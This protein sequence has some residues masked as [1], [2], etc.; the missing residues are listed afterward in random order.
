MQAVGHVIG[1]IAE[2]HSAGFAHRK[3]KPEH[4]CCDP[5]LTCFWRATNF[6]DAALVGELA[7][8]IRPSYYGP[9]ERVIAFENGNVLESVDRTADV[10]AMGVIAFE[11]LVRRPA[12]TGFTFTEV[13][14][15]SVY[16]YSS[17]LM[18]LKIFR[19]FGPWQ[20]S[21]LQDAKRNNGAN[22]KL[23]GSLVVLSECSG[24][25]RSIC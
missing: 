12:F 1:G 8:I 11:L 24:I 17:R 19:P 16:R 5:Q 23:D 2:F 4:I 13:C 20:A 10:W 9:P 6:D 22:S 14:L 21:Q 7:P 15:C 3:I 25:V 18:C